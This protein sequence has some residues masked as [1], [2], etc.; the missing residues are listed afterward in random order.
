MPNTTVLARFLWTV[1]VMAR[2]GFIVVV[3]ERSCHLLIANLACAAASFG[4]V[5]G[6]DALHCNAGCRAKWDV[7]QKRAVHTA[8]TSILHP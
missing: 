2:N 6:A 4:T 8:A 7:A 3:G 5:S 1:G